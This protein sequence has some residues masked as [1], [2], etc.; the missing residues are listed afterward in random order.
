MHIKN[1]C[2][3]E[4]LYF[5]TTIKTTHEDPCIIFQAFLLIEKGFIDNNFKNIK[6]FEQFIKAL[7]R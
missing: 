1:N 2:A 6:K 3:C 5:W 4:S 7:N